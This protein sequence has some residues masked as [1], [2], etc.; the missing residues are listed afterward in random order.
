MVPNSVEVLERLRSLVAEKLDV[1]QLALQADARLADIG[2]D[3]FS[4]VEL[5]F[6]V[7]EE[8]NVKIPF[9]GLAVETVNDVIDVIQQRLGLA[10][11]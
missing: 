10:A 6:L 11:K 8:F 1:E 5:V 3:S 2:I 7:E 4:L 9:E